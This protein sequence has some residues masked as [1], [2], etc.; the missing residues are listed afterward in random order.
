MVREATR[1][2][3]SRQ[4][5]RALLAR[6]GLLERRP[7]SLPDALDAMGTL[8]AQYAPSMYIGLW[9][10]VEGFARDALTEALQNRAVVQGTLMR[11]TIH[12]VSRADY[13]PLAIAI[14][15][16]R[17][18]AWMRA[19]KRPELGAVANELRHADWP[20]KRTDL[21]ALIGKEDARGVGLWL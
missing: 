9:S 19:T 12:L 7:L 17:R 8:Q 3:S 21:E 20:L 13:W 1:I 16:A 5:N 11:N 10:R 15:Q 6:Q 4:L 14:R 18:E 2:L